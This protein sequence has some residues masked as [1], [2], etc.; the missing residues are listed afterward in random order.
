[1]GLMLCYV[2][3]IFIM[4]QK[5]ERVH[6]SVPF[7]F[8]NILIGENSLDFLKRGKKLFQGRSPLHLLHKYKI[9]IPV[10]KNIVNHPPIKS[11]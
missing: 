1:M 6:E 9:I 5:K 2:S 4:G 11:H 10:L 7:R 3:F 8:V